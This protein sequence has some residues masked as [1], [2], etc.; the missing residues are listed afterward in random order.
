MGTSPDVGGR[1]GMG[2]PLVPEYQELEAQAQT[3]VAKQGLAIV[4]NTLD[5]PFTEMGKDLWKY[6]SHPAKPKVPQNVLKAVRHPEIE[7]EN[8]RNEEVFQELVD[9]LPLQLSLKLKKDRKLPYEERDPQF[10]IL[11]RILAFHAKILIWLE[12][13]QAVDRQELE[14][15]TS[16]YLAFPHYMLREWSTAAKDAVNSLEEAND[17]SSAE[18]NQ[19]ILEPMIE[20]VESFFQA[21]EPKE[22]GKILKSLYT[23]AD[24]TFKNLVRKKIDLA[25][26]HT[27][28]LMSGLINILSSLMTTRGS[29]TMLTLAI[30]G[31]HLGSPPYTNKVFGRAYR[32]IFRQF[33]ETN[34]EF[35]FMQQH[36]IPLIFGVL[37]QAY[38]ILTIAAAGIV[39]REGKQKE[40]KRLDKE[41]Y[42]SLA[43]TLASC[44]ITELRITYE[45]AK[46]LFSVLN[47]KNK[48]WERLSKAADLLAVNCMILAGAKGEKELKS[49]QPLLKGVHGPLIHLLQ[50]FKMDLDEQKK[51]PA[52]ALLN[53]AVRQ[54]ALAAKRGS[55]EGYLSGVKRAMKAVRY[56]LDHLIDE[57]DRIALVSKRWLEGVYQS[58]EQGNY[59]SVVTQAA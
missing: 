11:E 30:S 45:G 26:R 14:E 37:V 12:E 18:V 22:Q 27:M 44:L 15:V 3:L 57:S 35:S 46:A 10:I 32:R 58:Q 34:E 4:P 41:I 38:S 8:P 24:K 48:D 17:Q 42:Q 50:S 9:K 1:T 40:D 54:T 51:S 21:K 13:V 59:M 31:Q 55:A 6:Q 16:K 28:H 2:K 43:F 33:R 36:Y 47:L 19:R 56:P 53:I 49:S 29:S 20:Q 7:K 52:V 23:E 25:A 39:G 5:I